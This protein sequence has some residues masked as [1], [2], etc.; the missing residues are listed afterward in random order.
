MLGI[1]TPSIAASVVKVKP[2]IYG[3]DDHFVEPAMGRTVRWST[4][5][6]VTALV[7]CEQPVPAARSLVDFE[8]IHKS[9]SMAPCKPLV[10]AFDN[11]PGGVAFLILSREQA[12][13]TLTNPNWRRHKLAVR[14]NYPL[15]VVVAVLLCHLNP[16]R[17]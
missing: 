2:L 5:V 13:A 15:R 7:D 6:A 3:A 8:T 11:A 1:D 10:L 9:N 17:S 12:T 16:C 4:H 14:I